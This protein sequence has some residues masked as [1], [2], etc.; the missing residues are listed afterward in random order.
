M[1]YFGEHGWHTG[2]RPRLPPIRPEFGSCV[3]SLHCFKRVFSGYSSLPPLFESK[4]LICPRFVSHVDSLPYSERVFSGHSGLPP[5]FESKYL[6]CPKFG[7]YVG[8]LLCS[9]RVFSGYSGLPPLFESKIGLIWFETRLI[10]I[11]SPIS[12]SALDII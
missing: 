9:E 6:I 2:R 4:Y 7:S 11:V 10:F 12:S 8:S 3:G 1:F 5:L